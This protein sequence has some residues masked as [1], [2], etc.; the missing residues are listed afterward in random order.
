MFHIWGYFDFTS[1]KMISDLVEVYLVFDLIYFAHS[2][3]H[4]TLLYPSPGQM[5][6]TNRG[7]A[8]LSSTH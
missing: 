3:L 5:T 7:V 6:S 2:L 8:C 4:S 1:F